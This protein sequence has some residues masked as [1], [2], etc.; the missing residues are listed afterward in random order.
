MLSYELFLLVSGLFLAGLSVYLI[1]NLFLSTVN[2]SQ[3]QVLWS[4]SEESQRF[5]SPLMRFLLTLA[6]QL[7]IKYAPRLLNEKRRKVIEKKILTAGFSKI[8]NVNEFVALQILIGVLF[9]IVFFL[10]N[11]ALRMGWPWFLFLVI[12]FLGYKLPYIY[13]RMEK[14]KRDNSVLIEFPFFVDLLALSIEAGLEF[15]NALQKIVMKVK[16]E[17]ILSKEINIVLQDIK[18]GS[19]RQEALRGLEARL[20]LPE[21]SSFVN[22]VIDSSQTG[23]GIGEVLKQ[24]S[25]QIRAERFIKAEKKGAK[26]SVHILIP[27][28]LFIIPAIFIAV[29]APAVLTMFYGGG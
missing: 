4:D 25:H 13:C 5:N 26:A 10:M 9:P 19:S 18:I 15:I 11:F 29:M 20:D 1:A 16:K 14:Q 24:Q 22:L 27:M 3:N 2:A 12:G 8:L 28:A 6:R 23:V 17:S 7:T 21:V